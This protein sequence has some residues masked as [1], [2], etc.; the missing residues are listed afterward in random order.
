MNSRP[1]SILS[2][3][4]PTSTY[5]AALDYETSPSSPSSDIEHSTGKLKLKT[6]F[7]IIFPHSKAFRRRSTIDAP[8]STSAAATAGGS[9]PPSSYNSSAVS[10]AAPIG[11]DSTWSPKEDSVP[12]GAA[13]GEGI[14]GQSSATAISMDV[15]SL[16]PTGP[17]KSPQHTALP[18]MLRSLSQSVVRKVL[19]RPQFG[20]RSQPPNISSDSSPLASPQEP[21]HSNVGVPAVSSRPSLV[22]RHTSGSADESPIRQLHSHARTSSQPTPA[23]PD[24]QPPELKQSEQQ[25]GAAGASS[26]S[27]SPTRRITRIEEP[28][29]APRHRT[30]TYQEARS[31]ARQLGASG[32]MECSAMTLVNVVKVFDEAVRVAGTNLLHHS[33][34]A[35]SVTVE[36]R[37]AP[38]SSLHARGRRG[39][40]NEECVIF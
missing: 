40:R 17:P 34:H 19:S 28:H 36:R 23:V 33:S 22:H 13:T 12:K 4:G 24:D 37:N 32:Y 27:T 38:A 2:N 11:T 3:P 21:L 1:I 31:V 35:H 20:T 5:T 15:K 39:S 26:P 9:N 8:A 29:I 25:K 7:S 6:P 14:A 30:T 10:R 18:P 16:S